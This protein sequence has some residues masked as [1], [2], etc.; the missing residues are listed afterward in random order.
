[1]I[2][3]IFI[4]SDVGRTYIFFNLAYCI[5]A[6]SKLYDSTD[7][8]VLSNLLKKHMFRV[9]FNKF[10]TNL[11]KIKMLSDLQRRFMRRRVGCHSTALHTR[12]TVLTCT[13]LHQPIITTH[14]NIM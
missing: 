2:C 3:Y 5:Y 7:N 1:M 10:I 9:A 11:E 13:A 4:M 12:I 8:L 14:T 6:V